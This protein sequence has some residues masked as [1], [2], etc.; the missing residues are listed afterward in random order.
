MKPSVKPVRRSCFASSIAEGLFSALGTEVARSC[1]DSLKSGRVLDYLTR[2]IDPLSYDDWRAFFADYQAVNLLSKFPNFDIP[3]DRAAVAL[4][5]FRKSEQ[6]CLETNRRVSLMYRLRNNLPESTVSILNASRFKI[7]KLLGDFSWNEASTGFGF[8]PGANVGVRRRCGDAWYKFGMLKPTTTQGNL[9]LAVAAVLAVPRWHCHLTENY[10]RDI[11]DCFTIV[12]GNKV[13]T[14]PKN[15]KTDRI[16]AVEPLMNMFVQK[17]IG[18]M[19]RRRL[20]RVGVDLDSQERN[21]DLAREGSL[22]GALAT[23]D[24]SSASDS[25][26]TELVDWLLPDDWSTAIKLCR[27]PRGVL[28]DGELI[29]YQKVS[30]M[31]NGFTFELESLIFWA[32]CSSVMSYLKEPDRRLAIYGDDIVIPRSCV[33]VLSEILG[34]SGFV[35]NGEKSFWNGPFRESCGKH[36]FL[37]RDV[38]PIYIRKAV[39]DTERLL[40][41]A[42]SIRRLAYRFSGFDYG[43]DERFMAVHRETVKR[44]P[45]KLRRP[46]ICDGLGDGALVGDFDEV[47]PRRFNH[48]YDGWLVQF[49][50]REYSSF[51][52]GEI[53]MLVKALYGLERQ[54][55]PLP[56]FEALIADYAR[57]LGNISDG[58]DQAIIPLARYR[59]RKVKTVTQQWRNLGPWVTS[60]LD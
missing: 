42:N 53:P 11:R 45:M 23:V 10:S 49:Q 31:G 27:S 14:V 51:V 20:V 16:I 28:P 34:F 38:T 48:Q 9:A 8:G 56:Q 30:S 6:S 43:C 58:V 17:G 55:T 52:A 59:L 50:R 18:S 35:F 29:T 5:K 39:D 13:I 60:F 7:H 36:Y 33:D 1:A 15:A 24:L 22:E 25:V 57:N 47:C 3:I 26:S 2:S 54:S 32:L 21:Q 19:I 40:W 41:A 44:L 12:P 46:T 4:E 37:G